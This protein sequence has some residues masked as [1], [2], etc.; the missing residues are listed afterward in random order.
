MEYDI[1]HVNNGESIYK[2]AILY[3]ALYVTDKTANINSPMSGTDH[4]HRYNSILQ[5]SMH[6]RTHT[7]SIAYLYL[8]S[9][10]L[11]HS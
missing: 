1:H 6:A 2:V 5:T 3:T 8:R 4:G 7:M 11:L 9:K 10:I